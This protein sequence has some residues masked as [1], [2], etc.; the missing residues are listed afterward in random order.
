MPDV[1]VVSAV[2]GVRGVE[3][4]KTGEEVTMENH[5]SHSADPPRVQKKESD[6]FSLPSLSMAGIEDLSREQL[7]EMLTRCIETESKRLSGER[8]L[9]AELMLQLSSAPNFNEGIAN[10]TR[11]LQSWSGCEAV[12]IRLRSGDDYP[13]CETRGFPAEF[14][15]LENSLCGHEGDGELI[16]DIEGNPVL[17]CMCGNVLSGRVDPSLPFFTEGGSF[18][19][20]NTTRLLASTTRA[21]RQTRTRNRCN[22]EGYES[23]ALIPLR[24]DR[25]V[26]GLVQL[27]D[28]RPGR[29]SFEFI[30]HIERIANILALTMARMQAEEEVR[31]SEEQFY[32]L[33]AFAYAMET[34]RLPDGTF[35]YV[36]PSCE[37]VT[38]FPA[39]AYLANPELL[40]DIV[41]PKDK[42]IFSDHVCHVMGGEGKND[43][44]GE[45]EFRIITPD[46]Q[47]RWLSHSCSPIY[48]K[49]GRW[50]GRR[51]SYRD[52]TKR[53]ET[54]K[55][56]EGLE[57]KL[58]YLE[59]QK[60]LE[61]MAGAIV[62]HFNN[63]LHVI[64]VYLK[65]SM[66][67][68][69]IHNAS[70]YNMAAALDAAEKA[71]EVSKLMLTYLGQAQGKR[72]P[73]DLA[74]IC[75][76]YYGKL[77]NSLPKNVELEMDLPVDGPT[78]D[79]NEVQIQQILKRLVTNAYE[80]TGTA[81]D[82]ILLGVEMVSAADV[83]T[84]HRFPCDWV[85]EDS[86]YACLRVHDN[87]CGLSSEDLENAFDPFY[88][89]KFTGRGL[90]LPVVLG[91]VQAHKGVISVESSP[92]A[93]STFSIYL[94]LS[95]K[96]VSD[97]SH[98]SPARD[99]SAPITSEGK[100]L[101]VDDDDVV[102]EINSH[103]I[104]MLGFEVLRARDGV[105]GIDVFKKHQS[106]IRFVLSDFAMP[107]KNGLEM[108]SILR[109]M[110]PDIPVILASGYSE[111]L[112]MGGEN[113]D[114]PQYFLGKPFTLD[115]LR[116]VVSVAL[117]PADGFE[118]A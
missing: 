113:A 10:L 15:R 28:R 107:R 86:S 2:H 54:E 104:T 65:L 116:D 71:S 19:S 62:H 78:V 26:M 102:L 70:R 36:S 101:V 43:R 96:D 66:D 30:T 9:V 79:T 8:E 48:D 90:G 89:T 68:L 25:E 47:V 74:R 105:E 14:V 87:G 46:G 52:I 51:G 35:R 91:L 67:T 82:T 5:V 88:S 80:A 108:A 117:F 76:A 99:R 81:K 37:R 84:T 50:Q 85:A 17:E 24:T 115:E 31:K 18:W 33:A 4:S 21:E 58:Y 110:A 72:E 27:N 93:G 6:S 75:R 97:I 103:L 41:H 16:R 61:R 22:G 94:P 112:V 57:K 69:P 73:L 77:K 60:S 34:W 20:N 39:E 13:Y 64:Q 59:K 92:G 38:G 95:V 53:I 109:D 23:V 1:Q 114:F 55:A 100:V 40:E 111:D 83:P 42:E 98:Y 3:I 63:K 7:R 44:N 12:G 32:T 45:L 11:F 49:D 56:K 118:D 29:F 106:E